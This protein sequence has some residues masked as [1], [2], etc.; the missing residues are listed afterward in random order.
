[1]ITLF[2]D[3]TCILCSTNASKVKEKAPQKIAV[4]SV[5]EGIDIL[6]QANISRVEAMT[7]VCVQDETGKMHKGMQAVRLLYDT[8]EM[9]IAPFLHLPLVKPFCDWSYPILARHRHRFPKWLIR[10]LFG[11]ITQARC[12]SDF[13]GLS[14]KQ[15]HL[16]SND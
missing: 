9:K 7:Y 6:R 13:C 1:M 4:Q 8:A 11:S 10:L 5:D 3:D 12:T 16:H 14:P 2:Y 15:R